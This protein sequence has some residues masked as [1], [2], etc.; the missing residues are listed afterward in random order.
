MLLLGAFALIVLSI[1]SA[2]G[3]TVNYIYDDLNRLRRVDFGNGAY[4]E[5]DYD[6][7]GKGLW[8]PTLILRFLGPFTAFPG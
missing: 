6:E 7:A 4:I 3:E 2:F 5:Y 1:F 8:G